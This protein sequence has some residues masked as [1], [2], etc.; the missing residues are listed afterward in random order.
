MKTIHAR[1]KGT[2]L[3]VGVQVVGEKSILLSSY[4]EDEDIKREYEKKY[5][6]LKVVWED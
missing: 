5:P 6:D 3:G 1:I 4:T 2:M